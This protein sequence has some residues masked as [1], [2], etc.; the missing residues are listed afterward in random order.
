M[1]FSYTIPPYISANGGLLQL[2]FLPYDSYVKVSYNSTQSSYSYPNSLAI[3]DANGNSYTNSIL[4][5]STSSPN[6]VT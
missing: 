5:D 1:S 4:Y 3:T 2:I 6:S